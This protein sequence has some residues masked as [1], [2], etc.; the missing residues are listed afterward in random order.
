[1]AIFKRLHL[2]LVAANSVLGG[3]LSS[4]ELLFKELQACL[5]YCDTLCVGILLRLTARN[6]V[7]DA[8]TQILVDAELLADLDR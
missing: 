7:R 2:L 4:I 5:Q 3:I 8:L 1:M 6:S